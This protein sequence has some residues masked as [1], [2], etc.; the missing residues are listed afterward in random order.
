MNNIKNKNFDKEDPLFYLYSDAMYLKSVENFNPSRQWIGICGYLIKEDSFRR[1]FGSIEV[2]GDF[3]FVEIIPKNT[4]YKD[5]FIYNHNYLENKTIDIFWRDMAHSYSFNEIKDKDLERQ[6]FC[7]RGKIIKQNSTHVLFE[8][9]K[10]LIWAKDQE[11]FHKEY[12]Y[13]SIPKSYI[14]SVKI[15]ENWIDAELV[16]MIPEIDE[17]ILSGENSI[18]SIRENLN[19]KKDVNIYYSFYNKKYKT[20]F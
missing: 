20:S 13:V 11:V 15:D 14:R 3:L 18:F 10:H 8:I 12:N 6:Y 7:T 9:E 17:E 16:K 4:C 2:E 1:Y 5:Y 19:N